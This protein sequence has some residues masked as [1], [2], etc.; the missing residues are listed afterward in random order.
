MQ[1]I[2]SRSNIHM[3]TMVR[4]LICLLS[5]QQFM[6]SLT[7]TSGQSQEAST[8]SQHRWWQRLAGASCLPLTAQWSTCR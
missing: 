5:F 4:A 1:A 8:L 6:S 2:K 3:S 7:Y